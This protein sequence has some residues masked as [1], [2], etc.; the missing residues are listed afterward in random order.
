ME[1]VA[2]PLETQTAGHMIMFQEQGMTRR[3]GPMASPLQCFG[4]TRR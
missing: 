1:Q 4:G 2:I 3:A